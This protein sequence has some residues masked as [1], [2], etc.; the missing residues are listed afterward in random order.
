MRKFL[1]PF[2]LIVLKMVSWLHEWVR[3]VWGRN[4]RQPLGIEP[5]KPCLSLQS[6]ATELRVVK[7]GVWNGIGGCLAVTA[8]ERG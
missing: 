3:E 6:S 2:C 7:W 4:G 1:S 5:R 8:R